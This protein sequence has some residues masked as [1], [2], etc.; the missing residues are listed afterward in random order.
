MAASTLVFE[1]VNFVVLAIALGWAFT[2]PM[3]RL[4]DDERATRSKIET[5]TASAAAEAQKTRAELERR[6]AAAESDAEA[7][8]AQAREDAERRAEEIVAQ[9]RQ[10]AEAERR[11]AARE[12]E[13]QR[14]A[15]VDELAADLAR[16]VESIVLDVFL[17][18]GADVDAV[19]ARAANEELSKMLTTGGDH[20]V[21]ES[22][23]PLTDE[24]RSVLRIAMGSAFET[25]QLRVVPEL[26]AGVRVSGGAGLVDA[27]AR[28][29]AANAARS[30]TAGGR[31][32]R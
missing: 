14:R 24:A 15:A 22:A 1:V 26:V 25:A 18:A 17:R 6:L 4:L 11:R 10:R 9:G 30:L 27:S 5:E 29:I 32:A 31:D 19:L 23:H 28:G 2:K 20:V 13:Q 16:A 12:L 8:R 21:V 3:R 7:V